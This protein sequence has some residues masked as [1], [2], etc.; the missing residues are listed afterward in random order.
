MVA[1]WH[2]REGKIRIRRNGRGRTAVRS[3]NSSSAGRK[4]QR[5]CWKPFQRTELWLTETYEDSF[6]TATLEFQT[7]AMALFWGISGNNFLRTKEKKGKNTLHN[8]HHH[9]HQQGK[10][11]FQM[12]EWEGSKHTT[13]D[14]VLVSVRSWG[15]PAWS[16]E[17]QWYGWKT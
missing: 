2:W 14:Q 17:P 12:W 5:S 13:A 9:H 3:D 4:L 16:L 8:H 1:F 15:N 7:W 11:N 6:I 10:N